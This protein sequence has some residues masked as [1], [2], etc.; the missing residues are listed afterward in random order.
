MTTALD[1]SI[2][3]QKDL[4]WPRILQALADRASTEPG[5]DACL[6]LDFHEDYESAF[7]TLYAVDELVTLLTRG[8]DLPVSGTR[9]IKAALQK[10]KRGAVLAP[11]EL[12]AIAATA[13]S[14]VATR[15]H[16]L[17]HA[18]QHPRLGARGALL[19]NVQ[20]LAR[21]LSAT[22]D[23][24]GQIR[25][26][27]SPE[28]AAARQRLIGLHRHMKE[29]LESYIGRPE[30]DDVLQDRFYTQR[31]DRYVV[32]VIASFQKDVPGIIHGASNSG[33]TVFIEPG[34][35]I[36]G[37]N[38][39]KVADATVRVETERVLR[40]RSQWVAAESD[41]LALAFDTL[42]ELDTL[43]ARARLA[44]DLDATVPRLSR[45]GEIR[46][47]G[48]RNPHLLL[49]GTA[50]VPND[51]ALSP[52]ESFLVITGPNTGGKTV[53]LST[54][55][56]FVMM[57]AAGIPIP[58]SEASIVAPFASLSA[59]IG[60]AQDLERDLSTFSGHLLAIQHILDAA[61]PGA[62]VLLDEIITGTEPTQG[63][64]LAIAVLE[65][66]ASRGARGFVTTHYER[67][68]TLPYEDER[69]ANASVGLDE[70]THAPNFLLT[71]GRPGSSNP[72]D[73]ALR[74]G[75]PAHLVERARQVAGGHSGLA[76]ALDRLRTFEV[77]AEAARAEARAERD[78]LA[79]ETAR[80]LAERQRLKR[81]AR[82]EL[83]ALQRAAR[84]KIR[85]ALDELSALRQ[86]LP[87][88]VKEPRGEIAA[89][90]AITKLQE[91]IREALPPAED[92][93][94]PPSDDP[95]DAGELADKDKRV[96]ARV[97]VRSLAKAGEIVDLRGE[98]ATVAVG[99]L[100]T[101][102]H[103]ADLG[104][105]TGG[106][107]SPP[108]PRPQAP[109]A[110][111]HAFAPASGTSRTRTEELSEDDPRVPPPRTDEITADLRGRRRDEV[112]ERVEPLI[113][114]AWRDNVEA[115]WIIHGHGTGALRDEVRE[116][117]SRSPL[118]SG[119]RRG[120]RHEGGDGVTIAFLARD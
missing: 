77:E 6:D 91:Q 38:A 108:L 85:E 56:T 89:Q 57:I 22:F 73:I 93:K 12:V 24:S 20:S 25:D 19:P 79:S 17:H 68:K 97:W 82:A 54:V 42:V 51:I 64:S 109:S 52:T 4:G 14:C 9:E 83:D 78:R 116:L 30:L 59:L 107:S 66:L 41:D 67:L 7:E 72:F 102:V 120:R 23:A 96:G 26:D 113:D 75:F 49:K 104:R 1:V 3:H 101:S 84:A 53:T 39:I 34:E 81:E 112:V 62:L 70:A 110:A 33:E 32:P 15:R 98:R 90:Q 47:V 74:L 100:K 58:A 114:R 21:E 99:A 8:G 18:D 106:E 27:A 65:S 28:L 87:D 29:R 55:G 95:R 10:A 94:R 50:V 40:L 117:L 105:V 5:R 16:L 63:A 118:V 86:V 37:N 76:E 111:T 69:F 11:E 119:F 13:E 45:D 60:D 46:L 31:E 92:E 35:F 36:E 2:E 115:V 44:S 71:Q 48:A 88:K 80:L 43:M 61:E 103:L